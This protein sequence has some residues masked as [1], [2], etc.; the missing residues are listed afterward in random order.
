MAIDPRPQDDA[1]AK[2]ATAKEN[3]ALARAAAGAA[4]LKRAM[5]NP[6]SFKLVSALQFPDGSVCYEY[7]GTNSFNAVI[8]ANAVLPAT[9]DALLSSEG[10]NRGQFVS[11]WNKHCA[12]R[13]KSGEEMARLVDRLLR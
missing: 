6:D 2:A 4:T 12:S 9:T 11:A 7:R 10:G 1:A 13:G 3:A 8:T 5:K